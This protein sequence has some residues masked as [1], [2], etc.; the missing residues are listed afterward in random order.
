MGPSQTAGHGCAPGLGPRPDRAHP[1]PIRP[2][3]RRPARNPQTRRRERRLPPQLESE[4]LPDRPKCPLPDGSAP[5]LRKTGAGRTGGTSGLYGGADW[6][7]AARRAPPMAR[8]GRLGSSR[9]LAG[10]GEVLAPDPQPFHGKSDC[11]R[12]TLH[13]SPSGRPSEEGSRRCPAS[14]GRGAVGRV[15]GFDRIAT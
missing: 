11:P 3:Q 8:V 15:V 9:A 10:G 1:Q 13:P 4:P 14:L 6:A 2:R 7:R 5:R 12:G